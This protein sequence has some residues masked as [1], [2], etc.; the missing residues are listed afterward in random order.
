MRSIYEQ[1]KDNLKDGIID[2]SFSLNEDDGSSIKWAPGAKDGVYI[3]H[4]QPQDFYEEDIQKIAQALECACGDDL[5]KSDEIF[6]EIT[7]NMSAIAMIDVFEQY[8]IDHQK[9]LDPL[10]IYR[11]AVYLI[12]NSRHIECVKTGMELLELMKIDEDTKEVIRTLGLYDEFTIFAAYVMR[13]WPSGNNEIFEMA[14]K[15]HG[16]GRIHCVELLE[17]ENEKIRHWLL[18]EGC[19]NEVMNAYS[20]YT[21]YEKANVKELL[22]KQPTYEEYKGISLIIEGLLDEGPITGISEIEDDKV[23]LL[24]FLEISENYDLTVSDYDAILTVSMWADENGEDYRE[25]SQICEKILH[26]EKCRSKVKEALKEGKGLRL[27]DVMGLPMAE[28]LYECLKKDF[29]SNYRKVVYVM[30]DEK[31]VEPTIRLF[32][33]H[34]PL[35]E[36]NEGTD[37]DFKHN[38]I[39]QF[40]LQE[41]DPYPGKG[42]ELVRA[43]LKSPELRSR[44]LSLEVLKKWVRKNQTSL[45]FISDELYE[46]VKEL[47]NKEDDPKNRDLINELI[48]WEE[49]FSE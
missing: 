1:L 37:T 43:G 46:I 39:L 48:R 32:K 40:I 20:A 41:L 30:N 28:E 3:Y 14:R 44:Y 7:Q 45:S 16:W 18:T 23:I 2:P 4:S 11:T 15:V 33:E 26:S 29:D 38:D 27:A 5:E 42:I 35:E 17:A 9:D 22:N 24:R 21:C 6:H 12:K 10:K 19:K 8:V 13:K 47:K 49:R 25:I 31:Y 34:L 36:M